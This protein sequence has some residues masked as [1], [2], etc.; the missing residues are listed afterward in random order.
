MPLLT[1]KLFLTA[2]VNVALESQPFPMICVNTVISI[3]FFLYL[4]MVR[5]FQ[6]AFTN[7]RVVFLE[8]LV[9]LVNSAFCVYQY[10]AAKSEYIKWLENT[11]LIGII[12]VSYTHLTLPTKA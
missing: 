3:V 6:S 7:F 10:F 2:L 9:C 5:P 8:L 4:L 11:V 12:A 1:T